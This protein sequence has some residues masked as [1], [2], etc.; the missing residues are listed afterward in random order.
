MKQDDKKTPI[1][2]EA[3]DP[4]LPVI[5]STVPGSLAESHKRN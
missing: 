5:H 2:W 1:A 4:E 3:K